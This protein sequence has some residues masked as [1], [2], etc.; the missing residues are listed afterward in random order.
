MRSCIEALTPEDAKPSYSMAQLA[1]SNEVL[2]KNMFRCR[3]I[4]DNGWCLGA[5]CPLYRGFGGVAPNRE[6]ERSSASLLPTSTVDGRYTKPAREREVNN[7]KNE[8]EREYWRGLFE[9]GK[10]IVAER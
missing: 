8:A 6:A 4:Y 3:T 7:Y 10:E 5:V 9:R 1:Y 2:G